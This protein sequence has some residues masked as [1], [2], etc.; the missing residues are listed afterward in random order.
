MFKHDL[1]DLVEDVSTTVSR[2][3]FDQLSPRIHLSLLLLL[4]A[5]IYIGSAWNPS[6][7]DDADAAHAEAAR[8]IV[9]RGDWVTL[10]ING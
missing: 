10:H 7:Q 9:E 8:E 2:P 5:L 1:P 4:A 3:A 6:L